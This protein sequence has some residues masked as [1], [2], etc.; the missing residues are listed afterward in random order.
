[1]KHLFDIYNVCLVK[2]VSPVTVNGDMKS[3]NF[4]NAFAIKRIPRV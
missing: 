2:V 3:L 1:M 4:I